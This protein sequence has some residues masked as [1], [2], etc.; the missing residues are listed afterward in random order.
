MPADP[1][2]AGRTP[3]AQ[4]IMRRLKEQWKIDAEFAEPGHDRWRVHKARAELLR[5]LITEFWNV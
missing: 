5:E 3:T 1:Q 4:D 2:T